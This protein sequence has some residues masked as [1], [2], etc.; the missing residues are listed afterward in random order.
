MAGSTCR[1]GGGCG[2]LC[3][4]P[5]HG[6]GTFLTPRVIY[7]PQSAVIVST[8]AEN[9]TA[10]RCR[11]IVLTSRKTRIK[12]HG[13]LIGTAPPQPQLARHSRARGLRRRHPGADQ[14]RPG[15]PRA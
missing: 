12:D 9:W 5:E 14:P 13:D 6:A 2:D 15:A 3:C 4:A 10:L 1:R 11:G 8:I 7:L